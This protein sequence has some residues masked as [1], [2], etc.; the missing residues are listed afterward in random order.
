MTQVSHSTM[1]YST[2]SHSLVPR[3]LAPEGPGPL[4]APDDEPRLW[5][6]RAA[7]HRRAALDAAPLVLDAEE[8][9]RTA[10]FR[11]EG[12]RECYVVAH[13]A[14][15]RLLGACLGRPPGEIELT[16]APCPLCGG[17]H[18]RP[19]VADAALHFSLS[20]SDG[21]VLLAV[22]G[23]PVGVDVERLPELRVADGIVPRLHPAE[24]AELS[25]LPPGERRAA[26]GRL[27]TR[28]EAY[29]K[30]LG[31]GLARDLSADYV[32]AGVHPRREPPG[33]RIDDVE[34]PDGYTAAVALARR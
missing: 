17:P 14:L 9:R 1:S 6:V 33:W 27:W 10:E 32:G 5:L 13:V 34:V 24:A 19:V 21:L 15:R 28:K 18:G 11:H 2:V 22:A 26:F 20:H 7:A 8:R 4:P 3:E 30:G 29:L 25:V 23:V 31:T 12:N 16:R